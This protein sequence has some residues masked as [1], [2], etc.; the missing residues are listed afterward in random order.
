MVSIRLVRTGRKNQP[1]FRIVVQEGKRAPK[2]AYIESLGNWSPLEK[3]RA[4]NKTRAAYWLSCGAKPTDSVWNIFVS[5][6]IIKGKKRA[7][8]A[9][10]KKK[11]EEKPAQN[12][13]APV[14]QESVKEEASSPAVEPEKKPETPASKE[15]EAKAKSAPKDSPKES[16]TEEK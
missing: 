2:A 14:A 4:I 3:R 15:S 11:E 6:G 7:V 5:E 16:K 1:S 9:L 12:V 8:H 10:S 13:E